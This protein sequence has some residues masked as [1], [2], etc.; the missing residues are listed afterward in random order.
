MIESDVTA[1]L[2]DLPLGGLR[3]LTSTGSTNDDALAW[4]AAGAQDF[5]VVVADEQTAGRGRS[6]R[7]WFTPAGSALALS[8]VLRPTPVER[9]LPGRITGLGALSVLQSCIQLGLHA[10]IKWPNDILLDG[11]KVAGILVETKWAGN[12]LA[13]SVLGIGVNLGLAAIP[14]SNELAFP[15]TSLETESGRPLQQTAILKEIVTALLAWRSRLGSPDFIRIWEDN[16]A[17]RQQLVSIG[18]DGEPQLSGK[19]DGLEPDG[20]LRLVANDM[21]TIVHF[22]EIHLRRSDDRIG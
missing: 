6:G 22:G 16:L 20:S 3:F 2:L 10:Q 11:K 8:V 18:T 17:F 4:A 15:A 7:K 9:A 19:L 12:Q 1:A 5:S 13:A 14:P 21:P